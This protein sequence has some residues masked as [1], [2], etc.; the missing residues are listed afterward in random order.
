M[1]VQFYNTRP[2]VE[3]YLANIGENELDIVNSLLERND[4]HWR[5]DPYG[6]TKLTKVQILSLTSIL[7]DKQQAALFTKF[8][9]LAQHETVYGYGD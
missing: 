6:N 7:K 8:D 3:P 2:P 5:I 1:S 4:V 9:A